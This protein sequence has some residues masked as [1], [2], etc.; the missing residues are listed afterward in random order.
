M[1]CV[2][3]WSYQLL[4]FHQID[5]YSQL[6]THRKWFFPRYRVSCWF[7]P[8]ICICLRS[9]FPTSIA[10]RQVEIDTC[11]STQHSTYRESRQ[12]RSEDKPEIV[13]LCNRIGLVDKMKDPKKVEMALWKIIPPEEG[14]SFC[15][16]LVNHGREVC[17]ARTK[18]Y[19][20]KCCLQD[21]CKKV[22]VK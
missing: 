19:C 2:T 22:D 4:R 18:P 3:V 21:I 10:Q 5:V 15:H 8:S 7:L 16:R 12:I 13:R 17:T 14:N 20:D 6:G 1:C 11:S 9:L